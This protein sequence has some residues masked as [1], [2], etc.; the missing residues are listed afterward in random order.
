VSPKVSSFLRIPDP[1][2]AARL[3]HS[4]TPTDHLA[5]EV[6]VALSTGKNCGQAMWAGSGAVVFRGDRS[7][8]LAVLERCHGA[9]YAVSHWRTNFPTPSVPVWSGSVEV[10]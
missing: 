8:V 6:A 2:E 10:P 7:S 4:T 1:V 3:R 9:G 5:Y